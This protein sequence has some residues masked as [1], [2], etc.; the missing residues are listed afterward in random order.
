M[1]QRLFNTLNIKASESNQVFDLLSVQFFIG[2]TNA[3]LNIISFSLFIYNFPITKLPVVYVTIA[4]VLMILNFLYEKLEHRLSPIQLLKII[5]GIAI[6]IIFSLWIGLSWGNKHDFIFILLVTNTII[7][8]ITG[9]AFWGLVSLLFN[10]RESRRVFSIVGSGDIPAKFIGYLIAPLLIPFI[11]LVNLLWLAMFSLVTSLV[12]FNKV[13]QKKSWEG[14]RKKISHEHQHHTHVHQKQNLVTFFFENKLIFTISLLSILSYNVFVLIDYTF[15]SQVKLKFENISELAIYIAVFFAVGRAIAIIFKLIFTSRIIEK[16]GIIYC[17]FITPVALSLFCILFFVFEGHTNYDVFIFGMMALLTEVLRSTMQEPVFFILFQPLKEQL[18]LKG[19][20]IAKGYTLP[21]SLII[22]GVSLF[23]FLRWGISLSIMFTIKIIIINLIIWA[24]VIFLI[25]KAY[26][27]TL[28]SSIKKGT[29][30]SDDNYV[31]DQ[32]TIDILLQKVTAGKN[33]EV[34]YALDLLKKAGYPDLA[35]LLYQKAAS[36]DKEIKKYALEQLET[37][38]KPNLQALKALLDK[39]TEQEIKQKIVSILCHHDAAYLDYVAENISSLEYDTRKTIIVNLL[40]QQEFHHLLK[41]GIEINNL[42]YSSNPGERHLAI[43]IITEL[44]HVQFTKDISYLINDEDTMVKR[45]AVMAAC[46]LKV[47]SLLPQILNLSDHP[48][49]KH[50]VLKALQQYGDKLFEDIQQLDD[51]IINHYTP[52]FIKIAANIKGEHSKQF[53]LTCV[54]TLGQQTNKTIHA[55]WSQN[56]EPLEPGGTEKLHTIL[57]KYMQSGV[58][59]ISDYHNIPDYNTEKEIVKNSLLN[60]IKTDLNISLKICAML[61]RKKP[62]NRILE[63]IDIEHHHKIYNA[64]EMIEL[65]LP[66]K[67]SKDLIV[68]FDFILDP[69]EKKSHLESTSISS[70]FSKVYLSD[71]FT[72]N[73]WTK[74]IV[75]YCSWKNNKTEDLEIVARQP[76]KSGHIIIEETRDFVLST[77][78]IN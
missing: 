53:L 46:K 50:L 14:T 7:Y 52:D 28:H 30:N 26:L 15:V 45:S 60:E 61:F 29:F 41:A 6:I 5:I 20:L 66:K 73:P 51:D 8:M 72:Y 40:N 54:E 77:T 74:S 68:L 34:I 75:M 43:N 4:V 71:G 12:L 76:E 23:F 64:I 36:G 55:L 21:P 13:I 2:L 10:V 27:K 67:I 37:S 69:N 16:L 62:I 57:H 1:K 25:Q 70:L 11:G 17:L 39:E 49:D 3:F 38:P 9:Y 32:K 65:E 78:L 58:H 22:V 47:S 33:A 44:K 35:N 59:K 19:H 63:L 42:I 48:E 56:Y 18:R 24:G 31:Y